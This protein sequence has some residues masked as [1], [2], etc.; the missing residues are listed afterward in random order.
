M[1]RNEGGHIPRSAF[2]AIHVVVV[3]RHDIADMLK[4]SP[5]RLHPVGC[6]RRPGTVRK[7]KYGASEW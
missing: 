2:S 6:A 5:P 1:A 4:S 7:E 3:K